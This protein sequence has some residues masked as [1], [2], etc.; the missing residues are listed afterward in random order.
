MKRIPIICF[1][2]FVLLGCATTNLCSVGFDDSPKGKP[3][4]ERATIY[5][6]RDNVSPTMMNPGI[7]VDGNKVGEL[8]NNSFFWAYARPGKKLIETEWPWLAGA[9]N[10]TIQISVE[11]NRTY[12]LMLKQTGRPSYLGITSRG[13]Y[14]SKFFDVD[15]TQAVSRMSKFKYYIVK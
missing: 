15:E 8:P 10:D 6:I 5:F 2:L 7:F 11:P 1:L 13:Y 12:Y 14:G 3:N 4:E 9:T